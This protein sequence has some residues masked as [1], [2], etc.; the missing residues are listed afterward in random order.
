M[1]LHSIDIK[2]FR[3]LKTLHLE[4]Q[5]GLNVLVG[6]NNT[7]KTNLL[8]AIRHA[9]GPAASR[10]DS[11]WLDRD[12]FYKASATAA[13]ETTMAVT[14]VFTGLNEAQRAHFYEITEFDLGNLDNSKATV[15]FE[16]S[17]PKGKKQASIKRTGGPLSAEQPEV[18]SAILESLPITFLPAL[19]DA[20]AALAPGYR[21]RLALLLRDIA[22][23]KGTN[24]KDGIVAIFKK[25]NSEL[26]AQ[27]L[28]SEVSDS[29]SKRTK[30]LAGTD[31]VPSTINTADA[32]FEKILRTLQVQMKDCPLGDLSANGLGLNNLLYISV[33]LEHLKQDSIDESPLLLVEEPEAH[34]H[35]QLT[36]LLAD[37]LAKTTPGNST[38][39]TL[40][41]THSPTLAASVPPSRVSV[42]F[43]D[44]QSGMPYCNSVAKSGMDKREQ[45]QLQ[46]MMDITRATLYF[47]KGL[48]L[49]E[50]ISESL[51]IP[52][53]A[54]RLGYDLASQ[55]ISVVPICGVAFET[56]KKLFQPTALGIP[57]AIVSD[58]DPSVER[59]DNWE[60][61][62]AEME[63]GTFTVCARMKNL[64]SLFSG[65]SNVR[66]FSSK[67][68]LEYD[69]AE[70]GDDNAMV[71]ATV[72]ESCFTGT[73]GTFNTTRVTSAGTEREQKALAAWR[74]I[75]RADH[76]GSKAEFA[77]HLAASLEKTIAGGQPAMAFD[78]PLYIKT[79]IEHVV[80]R[81]K[82]ITA[83]HN[84]TEP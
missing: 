59:G 53:L 72:W 62:T 17:W 37:Y 78:V 43:S 22:N 29:L 1:H 7:G 63:G 39:Q 83:T 48:I 60:S 4:L 33:V 42:L 2:N 25:A 41:T 68:T 80:N 46:R 18:P 16:A 27:P 28:V 54:K 14:L 84:P 73:P 34:L 71:M 30:N 50:G 56:F 15:R 52:V 57:V 20:E 6:R 12:D 77:H 9:L 40:V 3:S 61:D 31:H 36:M 81:L 49:V 47:A 13:A 35:P 45:D 69:L 58:A 23:R 79:A 76:T 51:L 44:S 10:G 11:L 67:L 64:F 24:A 32:D 74:G 26:I 70:A 75:C 19:R 82:P 38:P 5:S 55:H 66:V 8:H 65:Q 21:S